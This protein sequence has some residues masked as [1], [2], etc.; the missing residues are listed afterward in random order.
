[1]A[2]APVPRK[3]AGLP[4]LELARMRAVCHERSMT[5]WVDALY[6][7]AA[8]FKPVRAAHDP[9]GK[10]ANAHLGALLEVEGA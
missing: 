1:M 9:L 3:R 5:N 6:P 8:D 2:G 7:K 10:F 4:F